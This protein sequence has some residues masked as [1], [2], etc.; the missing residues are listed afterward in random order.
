MSPGRKSTEIKQIGKKSGEKIKENMKSQIGKS[1]FSI[2][3]QKKSHPGYFAIKVMAFTKKSFFLF[4]VTS[5]T[6]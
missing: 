6:L 3:D 2:P 1:N 5:A 4:T